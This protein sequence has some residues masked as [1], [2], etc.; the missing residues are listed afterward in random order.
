MAGINDGTI[1][2]GAPHRTGE[3]QRAWRY[4]ATGANAFRVINDTPYTSY[5]VGAGLGSPETQANLPR[6]AGWRTIAQTVAD[7]I[8]GAI[9]AAQAAVRAMLRNRR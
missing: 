5:L 3:F 6:L 8:K 2:P 7:N 1:D 9:R 4:A